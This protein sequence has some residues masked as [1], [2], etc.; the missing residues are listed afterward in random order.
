MLLK[1]TAGPSARPGTPG[2]AQDD[3]RFLLLRATGL[4]LMRALEIAR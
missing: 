3:N 1:A 2:L 4:F